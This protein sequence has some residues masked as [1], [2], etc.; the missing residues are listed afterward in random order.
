M[1][2]PKLSSNARLCV[3]GAFIFLLFGGFMLP[4][5]I[6]SRARVE[7]MLQWPVTGATVVAAHTERRTSKN[8]RPWYHHALAYRFTLQDRTFSG[9][10]VFYGGTPPRWRTEEEARRALPAIG[11]T[12]QIRYNPADPADNVITVYRHSDSD[13]RLFRWL[14]GC[15]G[16]VGGVLM[17][18]AGRAWRAER[19][20]IG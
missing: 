20:R 5:Q 18:F 16:A 13:E 1:L 11:S 14:T 15:V 3:V 12:L 19:K 4:W 17:V 2:L 9:D 10:R 6:W 8:D 7:A